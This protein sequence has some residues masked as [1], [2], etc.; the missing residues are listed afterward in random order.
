MPKETVRDEVYGRDNEY[1]EIQVRW[2]RNRWVELATVNVDPALGDP[3]PGT[4][5]YMSLDR[6][7]LN[8][9]ISDLKRAGRQAFGEDQW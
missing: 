4:G 1:R 2:N 7:G 5:I 3:K 9:L 8:K 6:E